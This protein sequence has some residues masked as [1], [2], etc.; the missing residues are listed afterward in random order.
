M[1]STLSFLLI[2]AWPNLIKLA[3]TNRP[4]YF[5][6]DFLVA[7]FCL[8]L[9]LAFIIGF[10][11]FYEFPSFLQSI[12]HQFRFTL[13]AFIGGSILCIAYYLF[14]VCVF[15]VGVTYSIVAIFSIAMS[16]EAVITII[17]DPAGF[18]HSVLMALI[19][20]LICVFFLN[21]SCKKNIDKS[22]RSK[23]AITYA[24]ISGIILGFF[25]PLI[26]K[27]FDLAANVRLAPH[28]ALFFFSCGTLFSFFFISLLMKNKPL[29]PPP[30]TFKG[31]FKTPL[32]KHFFGALSGV[33][34][35][36]S[37]MCRLLSDVYKI[38]NYAFVLS[39]IYPLITAALGIFV[40]KEY[41]EHPKT[42]KYLI[43]GYI[44]FLL[45]GSFL[46]FHAWTIP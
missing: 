38:Y 34:W 20:F 45:G 27:S 43:F 41:V 6:W 21:I 39:H 22:Y 12:T 2:I 40:W 5:Y 15:L 29:I 26:A 24:G 10:S 44:F 28:V 31:Y 17:T 11:P 7:L 3:K 25:F 9:F 36:S 13:Q 35:G 42:Y 19:F 30:F 37:I 1:L 46:R 23:K 8:S 14:V 33:L 32:K 4:E 18:P 16:T